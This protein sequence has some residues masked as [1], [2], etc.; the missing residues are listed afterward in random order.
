VARQITKGLI[1]RSD[2]RGYDAALKILEL[3]HDPVLGRDAATALGV[4]AEEGDRVL[5]KENFA[6]IR[7]SPFFFFFFFFYISRA[8]LR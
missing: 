7:L 6:V 2:Q 1:V 5:S 8:N 3:F 4:I